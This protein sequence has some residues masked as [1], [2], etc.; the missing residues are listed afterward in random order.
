MVRMI[1]VIKLTTIFAQG[2]LS[3]IITNTKKE[4]DV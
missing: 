4:N 2:Y 3:L 1:A